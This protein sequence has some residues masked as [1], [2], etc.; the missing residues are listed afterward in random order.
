MD[1]AKYDMQIQ[2]DALTNLGLTPFLEQVRVD[3]APDQGT[4]P[5]RNT[6]IKFFFCILCRFQVISVECQVR[7]A[8]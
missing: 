7:P 8:E 5:L 3:D 1:K 4:G 2:V 6:E